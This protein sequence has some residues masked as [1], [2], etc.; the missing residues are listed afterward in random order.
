VSAK[1]CPQCG[2]RYEGDNRF[3]PGPWAPDGS[4]FFLM[5][6]Q[7][8]DLAGLAFFRLADGAIDGTVFGLRRQQSRLADAGGFRRRSSNRSDPHR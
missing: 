2:T 6:D 7:G 3:Y 1:L 5:T 4:G 8:R